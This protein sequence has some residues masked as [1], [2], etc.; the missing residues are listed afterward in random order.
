MLRWSG[1]I[2]KREGC[3]SKKGDVGTEKLK[4][5]RHPSRSVV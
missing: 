5:L 4:S 1:L 3:I 2:R